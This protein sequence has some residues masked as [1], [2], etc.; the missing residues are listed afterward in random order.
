MKIRIQSFWPAIG[1]FVLATILFCLPGNELP[2]E[3]WLG[4]ISADKIVHIGLFGGL[5][6]LFGLPFVS[7]AETNADSSLR[8]TLIT[9]VVL[10]IAYGI[11]IEFI[12]GAFIPM[13]SFSV[14]DMI[15]DALGSVFGGVF[16]N[17]Q[18]AVKTK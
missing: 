1:M 2:D 14:A 7:K 12:Q 5:V 18:R 3:D 8:R 15:A 16:V 10:A 6:T 11:A 13:R 9:I 4:D 17:R